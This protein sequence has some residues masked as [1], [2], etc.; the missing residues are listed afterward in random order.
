MWKSGDHLEAV[1]LMRDYFLPRWRR[2][3]PFVLAAVF[4][5]ALIFLLYRADQAANLRDHAIALQR[6]EGYDFRSRCTLVPEAP[7]SL[8]MIVAQFAY[9]DTGSMT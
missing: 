4:A 9:M 1:R 5:L 8:E 6:R 7:A 2:Y 3:V